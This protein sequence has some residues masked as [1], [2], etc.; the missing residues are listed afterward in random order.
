MS[1]E[2]PTL[3]QIHSTVW[4]VE[5]KVHRHRSPTPPRRHQLIGGGTINIRRGRPT[6]VTGEVLGRHMAEL[7]DR[8]RKGMIK[9]TNMT[10]ERLD[11]ETGK[12]LFPKLGSKPMP[13]PILDSAA[14]DRTYP[15]GVGIPMANLPGGKA[16]SQDVPHPQLLEPDMPEGLE[17]ELGDVEG[18]LAE[19]VVPNLP[20]LPP[21][22]ATSESPE[23]SS[24]DSPISDDD[25]PEGIEETEEPTEETKPE[26]DAPVAPTQVESSKQ[27]KHHGKNK[28]GR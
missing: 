25:I 5:T 4:D 12:V 15:G 17:E 19:E 2:K 18:L 26:E 20:G 10:G 21:A 28:H 3:Y 7:Q 16:L 23:D 22:E 11:L 13:E 8:E 6:V 1:Q 24:V 14:N 9:V 27:G